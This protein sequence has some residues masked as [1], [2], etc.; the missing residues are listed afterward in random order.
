[1]GTAN[2]LDFMAKTRAKT[3]REF[4][5]TYVCENCFKEVT[6]QVQ[7][8]MPCHSQECHCGARAVLYVVTKI[9]DS[10]RS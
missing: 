7:L 2:L 10:N 5:R 8:W 1:M 9:S 4:H 3:L 6:G